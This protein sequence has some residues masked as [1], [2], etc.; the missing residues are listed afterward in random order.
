M[1]DVRWTYIKTS[2]PAKDACVLIS[3]VDEEMYVASFSENDD[4]FV[5]N[6]PGQFETETLKVSEVVAWFDLPNFPKI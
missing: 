2:L 6:I 5:I 3:S 1:Y 4:L